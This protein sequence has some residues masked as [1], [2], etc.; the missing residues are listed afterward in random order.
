M[1]AVPKKSSTLFLHDGRQIE[2]AL[3]VERKSISHW[4]KNKERIAGVDNHII[5]R[6]PTNST[7]PPTN[8]SFEFVINLGKYLFILFALGGTGFALG[9]FSSL[10]T[11]L[12]IGIVSV[13][14]VRCQCGRINNLNSI[15]TTFHALNRHRTELDG[16]G[17]SNGRERETEKRLLH[18]TLRDILIPHDIC[19]FYRIRKPY[20]GPEW[21]IMRL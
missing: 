1:T 14:R 10:G 5:C 19:R 13:Y 17:T 8:I 7:S 16:R 4:A 21:K 9:L 12:R 11:S 18:S 20:C 3:E 6:S 15:K 2:H